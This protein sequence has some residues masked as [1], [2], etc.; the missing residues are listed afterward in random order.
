MSK[1]NDIFK[2][3]MVKRNRNCNDILASVVLESTNG[4]MERNRFK[5]TMPAKVE[6]SI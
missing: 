5:Y 4:D 3:N 6:L 1:R 2:S